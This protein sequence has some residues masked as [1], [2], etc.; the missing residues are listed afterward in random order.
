MIA[1]CNVCSFDG[2]TSQFATTCGKTLHS[3][4]EHVFLVHWIVQDVV[5][6]FETFFFGE[7]WVFVSQQRCKICVVSFDLCKVD[8]SFVVDVTLGVRKLIGEMWHG[9][10]RYTTGH[11]F[12]SSA[13]AHVRHT[14]FKSWMS[15]NLN[16]W[17]PWRNPEVWIFFWKFKS[18]E[19]PNNFT[20]DSFK[21]VI[22]SFD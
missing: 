14:G 2:L 21:C 8:A 9:D 1:T 19:T 10:A 6:S 3:H 11:E 22:K 13:E 20:S 5:E 17:K 7:D 15:Q 18:F 12:E 4:L 16:L